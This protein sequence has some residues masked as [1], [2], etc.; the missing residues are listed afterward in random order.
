MYENTIKC[1]GQLIYGITDLKQKQIK[2]IQKSIIRTIWDMLN[3]Y[4]SSDRYAWLFYF[5]ILLYI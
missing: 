3:N 2:Q 5:Y 4:C 1:G